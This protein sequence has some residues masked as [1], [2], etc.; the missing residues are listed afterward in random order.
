MFKKLLNDPPESE[1]RR[2]RKPKIGFS[3]MI[4]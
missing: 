1:M 3:R 4:L 2:Y